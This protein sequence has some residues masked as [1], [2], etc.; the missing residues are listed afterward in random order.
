MDGPR[1]PSPPRGD[2]FNGT[3]RS[4]VCSVRNGRTGPSKA[5]RADFQSVSNVVVILPQEK[6]QHIM[7]EN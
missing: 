3:A 1:Q 5:R 2:A 7:K 4:V 6:P